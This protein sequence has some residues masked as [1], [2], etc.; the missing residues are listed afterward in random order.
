MTLMLTL[1][2]LIIGAQ[3]GVATVSRLRRVQSRLLGSMRKDGRIC[4]PLRPPSVEGLSPSR[5]VVL[6][7]AAHARSRYLSRITSE[8]NYGPA[9][10]SAHSVRLT[11]LDICNTTCSDISTFMPSLLTFRRSMAAIQA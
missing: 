9:G 1:M 7:N 3:A 11:V 6:L 4:S 10:E 8:R 2:I 5:S